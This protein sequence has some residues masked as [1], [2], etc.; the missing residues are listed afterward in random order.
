MVENQMDMRI[1]VLRSDNG[2][3]FCRKEFEHF[4]K[5]NGTSTTR[6]GIIH[7]TTIVETPQQN[8][9]CERKNRTAVEKVYYSIQIYQ[10]NFGPK[11]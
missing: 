1:K 5:V 4:L 11:Q 10:Q 3:E 8:G 2:G 7:Q 6:N 9:V